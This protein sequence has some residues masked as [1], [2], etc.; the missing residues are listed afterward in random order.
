MFD[1]PGESRVHPVSICKDNTLARF[2]RL[3]LLFLGLIIAQPVG[4]ASSPQGAGFV[5]LREQDY[6][7]S[8]S[9]LIDAIRIYRNS[10]VALDRQQGTILKTRNVMI[11]QV[12]AFR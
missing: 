6:V 11:D 2:N 3:T 9:A 10:T 7:G 8:Q 12:R 1:L 5:L 4:A